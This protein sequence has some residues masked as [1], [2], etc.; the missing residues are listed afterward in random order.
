M[1]LPAAEPFDDIRALV[2]K[3]PPRDA[4]ALAQA[5]AR[6]EN[7]VKPP[8]SLGR[9]EELAIW[10][11]GWPAD[12]EKSRPKPVINKP[13]VCVFAGSHG[14]AAHDVSAYPSSVNGV[15]LDIYQKGGAAINQICAQFNLGFKAFDLA[16]EHPTNDF[17]EQPALSE[18]NTVATMAFGMEAVSGGI[19]L[20][21][22]GEMGIGNTTSASAIYAALYG[23]EV[24]NWVGR[25]T[26][27][28]SSGIE[29]KA[30]VIRKALSVHQISLR[31][32]LSILQH[33]GGR[34][35][36]AMVGAI[37][38]ARMQRIP[39]MLDGF[40]A[41]AAAAVLHAL[42]PD[43]IGHCVAGHVSAEAAHRRVLSHL[44]LDPLLDLGMRLGEASGAALAVSLLQAAVACHNGMF[45]FEEAGI[46][47]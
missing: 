3:R 15:M 26:G 28:D 43:L 22:V 23:G 29:R 34:E 37:L 14:V 35:I 17:T 24:V 9:L 40:V 10:L 38:A 45:T 16:V 46:P 47:V 41:C 27:V 39:V 12:P 18:R 2:A 36:A 21:I 42:E 1:T 32:P 44:A 6:Q 30:S 8:G 20:L 5:R 33:L 11:S 31:D 25:G 13:L 4:Q 7:L 19:D